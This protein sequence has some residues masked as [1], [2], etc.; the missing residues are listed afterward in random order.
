M[1]KKRVK[2]RLLKVNFLAVFETNLYT[3]LILIE[4]FNYDGCLGKQKEEIRN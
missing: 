3:Q 2:S 1:T 4:P